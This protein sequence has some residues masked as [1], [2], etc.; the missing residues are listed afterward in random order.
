MNDRGIIAAFLLSPL[1]KTINPEHT[2]QLKLVQDPYSNR[3]KDLL[4]KQ[5]NT[6]YPS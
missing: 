2:S 6:S 4:N 5:S 3:V 1:S